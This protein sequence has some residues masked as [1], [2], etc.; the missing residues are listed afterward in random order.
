MGVDAD[1]L[2]ERL[3]ESLVAT[4]EVLTVY[5]G[6]RSG[7]YRALAEGPATGAELADRAGIAERY[8]RGSLE[9]Q[10]VAV[11][12][13]VDEVSAAAEARRYWMSDDHTQVLVGRS[14]PAR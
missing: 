9:P 13:D 10:A 2:S 7:L 12:I 8:A 11:L 3:F 4:G 14:G 1:A 5:L 6:D